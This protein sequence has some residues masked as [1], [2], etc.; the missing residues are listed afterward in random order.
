MSRRLQ[1]TSGVRA[2]EHAVL[3]FAASCVILA[4]CIALMA[5][6]PGIPT[7][8]SS[9][10]GVTP[11]YEGWYRDSDKLYLSF[12][13]VNLNTKEALSLPVGPN[14]KVEPGPLDQGQPT[15]FLPGRRT[16]VFAVEVPRSLVEKLQAGK[17]TVTWTLTANAK[18]SVIPANLGNLYA[19][20]ALKE[21]ASGNTPPKVAF[22][23]PGPVGTGV[24]GIRTERTAIVGQ[25]LQLDVYVTDDGVTKPHETRRPGLVALTW[26]K[27]RGEGE[28]VFANKNPRADDIAPGVTGHARTTATFS[29]A[30]RYTLWLDAIDQSRRDFQCCWTNAYVDV[31][32][33]GAGGQ[34]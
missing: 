7:R 12:G 8:H 22:D 9:G 16:G 29:A 13:Y 17:D 32:V 4:S 3:T 28:V 14:N 23:P 24:H 5:Q 6:L 20:N 34:R 15:Y 33:T 2:R 27:L 21:P 19:I 31:T 30:G 10:Q 18:V 11:V 26:E 1:I 25:P